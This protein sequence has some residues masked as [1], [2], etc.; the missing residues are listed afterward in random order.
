MLAVFCDRG[1]LIKPNA[2]HKNHK[3]NAPNEQN[4]KLKAK[5]IDEQS[6]LGNDLAPRRRN[7]MRQDDREWKEKKKYQIALNLSLWHSFAQSK[8]GWKKNYT[9]F[10]V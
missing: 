4:I 10:I 9:S 6:S 8:E 7:K 3:D 2:I 1:R 5:H